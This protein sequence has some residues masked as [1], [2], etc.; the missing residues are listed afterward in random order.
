MPVKKIT[1]EVNPHHRI[2]VPH[3]ARLN[4]GAINQDLLV[5]AATRDDI[6]N[7]LIGRIL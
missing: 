4:W 7:D 3:N 6:D 5:N 1:V 2:F